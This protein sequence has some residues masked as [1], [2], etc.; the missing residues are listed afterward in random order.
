M[1][2]VATTDAPDAVRQRFRTDYVY[3]DRET[4]ARYV[5]LKYG[6]ILAGRVLD[7]GCD[8]CHLRRYLPAGVEYWGIGRGGLPDQDAD[9]E[10][11]GVPF[12]DAS[13]D[14]VLCLDVLEHLDNIHAIFDDVCRVSA[15]YV[16]VSLPNPWGEFYRMLRHGDYR[17]GQP[18]KFYGLPSEPPED[19]HKW[20]F[21]AGEAREF[22]RHRA[23]RN[24][25][26]VVQIDSEDGGNAAGD[27]GAL[28]RTCAGDVPTCDDF[29]RANLY[30]GTIWAVLEKPQA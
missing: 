20:F 8:E 10:K 19:R 28:T 3:I 14:C 22:I 9:L 11:H 2:S 29:N 17:P 16:I 27:G 30:A 12:A 24:A 4:K 1:S 18:M 26:Q 5:W 6:P 7:V 15:R 13:F 25:M 21:S 23:R